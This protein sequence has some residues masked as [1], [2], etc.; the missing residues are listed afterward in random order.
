MFGANNQINFVAKEFSL[1]TEDWM[2]VK[3]NSQEVM[4]ST[5]SFSISNFDHE[6]D[7]MVELFGEKPCPKKFLQIAKDK[8]LTYQRRDKDQN[9][10]QIP[11]RSF[12]PV[13]N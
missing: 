1:S 13:S 4:P 9:G 7:V 12:N 11:P 2:E 5:L 6:K 3:E 8:C 10:N